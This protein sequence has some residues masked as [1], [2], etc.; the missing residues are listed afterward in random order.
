MTTYGGTETAVGDNPSRRKP[1][2]SAKNDNMFSDEL[3][4]IDWDETTERINSM[5]EA[6]VLRALAK[7]HLDV[8]DFMA[9]IRIWRRWP[10]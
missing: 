5:T 7:A 8:D 10:G 3:A 9:L 1:V 4:K 6:D 2:P